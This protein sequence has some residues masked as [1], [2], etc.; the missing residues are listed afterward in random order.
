MCNLFG[1][2][3]ESSRVGGTALPSE[4]RSCPKPLNKH[5]SAVSYIHFLLLQNKLAQM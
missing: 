4:V 3:P 5:A 1:P 2:H